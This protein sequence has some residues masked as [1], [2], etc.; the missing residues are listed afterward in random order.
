MA[1]SPKPLKSLE[2]HEQRFTGDWINMIFKKSDKKLLIR[3]LLLAISISLISYSVFHNNNLLLT[4]FVF[5][6]F[7]QFVDLFRFYSRVKTEVE[8][9]AES[10]HYRDFSRK[11]DTKNSP[12]ELEPLRKGF[13]EI[14]DTFKTISKE[15]ETQYLYLQK[16]LE[17]V[18]TAI[19][20]YEIETSEIGWIND[21]FKALL[22]IP[23]LKTIHSLEK[24]YPELYS[25]IIP[26]R[27][28][29]SKVVVINTEQDS[30]KILL[31]ATAF[32][33]DGKIF[34][35]VA[36]QNINEVL[37]E[38]ESVAWQKLLNVMTHE[39]MNSI[40][41]IS[42]L[43]NTL[44]NRLQQT[45]SADTDKT[46]S[47]LLE[48]MKLGIDTIKRRSEG[49]LKFAETYRNLNKISQL[50][51]TNV[52]VRNLF[53]NLYRLMEPTLEQKKIELE[54]FLRETDLSLNIDSGLVEQILINLVINAMEAVK[55]T[56]SPKIILSAEESEHH[57][58]I[59]KI[60]DNGN[61]ISQEHLEKIFIPFYTSKKNGTGIGLSLC[62]QIMAMHKGTIKVQSI[63]GK[64]TVFVLQFS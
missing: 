45:T 44:N 35:V 51:L 36:F 14:N 13:N 28:H 18:D 30:I 41:P 32:Q 1:T 61:G 37:D 59:I 5:I 17:M 10:A 60:S 19:L 64:G 22:G 33:T 2:L 9:F 48:D 6:I 42:S 11:Y 38:N 53:E 56:P 26:L 63:E 27:S 12:A 16:I 46:S 40:A 31:N 55:D 8:E 52:Y 34:K 23:Y 21:S 24:K 7:F 25:A 62:K 50:N 4:I 58:V 47:V 29:E 54:I 15:K 43:A 3:L 20:S 39:I 49:L 57:K